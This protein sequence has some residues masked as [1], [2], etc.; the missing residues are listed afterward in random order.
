[1]LS[2]LNS[3]CTFRCKHKFMS[4]YLKMSDFLDDYMGTKSPKTPS[5]TSAK[6]TDYL[7]VL[8]E[9][10]AFSV[11]LKQVQLSAVYKMLLLILLK[12]FSMA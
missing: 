7:K 6:P 9:K 2:C 8:L 4:N 5:D 12:A 3:L 1:M 10:K 11:C